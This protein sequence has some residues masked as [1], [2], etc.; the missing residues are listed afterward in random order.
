MRRINKTV[1][2]MAFTLEEKVPNHC[3]WSESFCSDAIGL[4]APFVPI[5]PKPVVLAASC[6]IHRLHQDS[7]EP[8]KEE[9]KRYSRQPGLN[10]TASCSFE[11]SR[12]FGC[13]SSSELR[14][15]TSAQHARIPARR[16]RA[17]L[18]R[19]TPQSRSR[20]PRSRPPLPHVQRERCAPGRESAAGIS[21]RGG[22]VVPMKLT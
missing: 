9:I 16:R 10:G 19:L 12:L 21:V 18:E 15:P 6:G 3:K 8:S 1:H 14:A 4:N 13:S 5:P 7:P 11:S 22:G 2:N 20:H 17:R